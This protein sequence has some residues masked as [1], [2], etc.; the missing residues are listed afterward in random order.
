MVYD[1]KG[2]ITLTTAIRIIARK[3]MWSK[4]QENRLCPKYHILIL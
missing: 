2:E 4:K 3:M 1:G